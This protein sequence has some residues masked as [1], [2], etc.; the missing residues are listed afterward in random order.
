MVFL[1]FP[2]SSQESLQ[3]T[4]R[5]LKQGGHEFTFVSCRLRGRTRHGRR[6][7]GKRRHLP[8]RLFI[9]VMPC[10]VSS[11]AEALTG[12]R[13]TPVNA[14]RRASSTFQTAAPTIG[15]SIAPRRPVSYTHL[16]AHETDS[17][18]VC[19]LLLETK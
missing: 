1:T 15:K 4:Y 17:Y 9:Q 13:S 11:S 12:A 16:R 19:R 3:P 6:L 5:S 8:D 2:V 18:L 10:S 14:T 7:A